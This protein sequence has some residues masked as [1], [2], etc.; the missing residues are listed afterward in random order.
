MDILYEIGA[1]VNSRP[2][3]RSGLARVLTINEDLEMLPGHVRHIGHEL[4]EGR[5]VRIESHQRALIMAGP[6]AVQN[7]RL[8]VGVQPRSRT[9]RL[10]LPTPA[11]CPP[12]YC[13]LVITKLSAYQATRSDRK[14]SVKTPLPVFFVSKAGPITEP[15]SVPCI[16][17]L[18][19]IYP[20]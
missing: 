13:N 11:G 2:R 4:A 19:S 9:L 17:S 6:L 16:T 18:P 3:F 14:P 15:S 1:F 7:R 8:T 20:L 12:V 5:R 10:R